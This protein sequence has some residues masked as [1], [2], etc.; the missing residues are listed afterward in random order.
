[1]TLKNAVNELMDFSKAHGNDLDV[2]YAKMAHEIK[3]GSRDFMKMAELDEAMA[4]LKNIANYKIAVE[5][6]KS[7][8][9]TDYDAAL[10]AWGK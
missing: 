1:M 9:D 7:G 5:A 4:F 10:E 6:R 3:S 8:D 2:S